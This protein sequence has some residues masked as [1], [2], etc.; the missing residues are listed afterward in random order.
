[1]AEKYRELSEEEKKIY[2]K[3]LTDVNPLLEELEYDIEKYRRY[4]DKG[5]EIEMR[6]NQRAAEYELKRLEDE[7]L[8][9]KDKLRIAKE[10]LEQG[11]LIK[12]ED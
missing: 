5:L 6:R 7:L 10:F 12:E 3:Q 9:S 1:M 2:E 8:V 4:L 11:V